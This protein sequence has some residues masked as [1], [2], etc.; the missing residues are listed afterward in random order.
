MNN[1]LRINDPKS[2]TTNDRY[3]ELPDAASASRFRPKLSAL[4]IA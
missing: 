4:A 3:F 2:K 1:Q